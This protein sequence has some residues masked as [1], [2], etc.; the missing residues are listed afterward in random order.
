MDGNMKLLLGM[1][2][3][4]GIVAVACAQDNRTQDT[5]RG[6]PKIMSTRE[7]NIEVMRKLFRTVEEHDEQ[8]AVGLY[9]PDVEFHWPPSL[10]YG[11]SHRGLRT[12][13]PTWG[14]TWAL[15]QPT[16]AERKMDPRI[17]AAS[18]DEVVALWHQRGL[19]PSGE[20]FDGEVLGLYRFCD[21][22][23]A[24]AQMF[25]FDT[26]AANNFLAKAITPEL[27]EKTQ[28]LFAQLRELPEERQLLMRQTYWKLQ[29]M[30]PD[31]R[32]IELRSG[33]SATT[34]SDD[35]REL[36]ERLLSLSSAHYK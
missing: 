32:R 26:T 20:R 33:N 24:R 35:E 9:H 34:F 22:K 18:D 13:G 10:P 16:A 36:L 17:V 15:M 7:K 12:S 2:L 31:Q 29:A 30:T 3:M 1:F 4:V 25:Y 14:E 27:R 5:N 28:A 6:Y 8:S 19:S 21:G 11:G 23:L